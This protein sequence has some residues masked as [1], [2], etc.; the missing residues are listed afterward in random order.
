MLKAIKTCR[1][2]PG[3]RSNR[4]RA[5]ANRL[6]PKRSARL[7]PT[8]RAGHSLRRLLLLSLSGVRIVDPKLRELGVTLPGFVERGKTIASLPSLSMLILAAHTPKNWHV[9]YRDLDVIPSDLV[10]TIVSENYEV[11]A[12]T[13]LTARIVEAYALA[14]Q[15]RSENVFVV[16]GGLHV[17]ALPEEA[18]QH[19]DAIVV[20]EGEP[21][22][23]AL[24]DDATNG[25]NK[26]VYRALPHRFTNADPVPRYDLIAGNQYNRITIQTCRGCPLD[27]SFCG[28]SRLISRF[29]CKPVDLLRREIET[30]LDQWSDPF[31]E[32]ADDNTFVHKRHGRAVARLLGEYQMAWFTETDI[33][34]ADDDE[35]LALLAES[36]CRQV[37]IG[38]ESAV[39]DSLGGIDGRQWKHQQWRAYREK[40]RRIQSAGISVNGCFVLGFDQDT[41]QTF[42]R[43]REFVEELEL[44]DVQITILTPFPGT[45]L[46]GTLA[47]ELRLAD[48]PFWPQCTLFDLT[49]QPKNMTASELHSGFSWLMQTLYNADAQRKRRRVFAQMRARAKASAATT[50]RDRITHS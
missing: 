21:V 14:D 15:L 41:P 2:S 42:E 5:S 3:N 9:D 23:R 37:L 4:V 50:A 35:L 47:R 19:A 16:L 17:S 32:L 33:S 31:I 49:F 24:L 26:T 48:Q 39:H 6:L 38:L 22:W 7:A 44:A 10:Q 20:G 27:C 1:I 30:I 12:I 43:T 34:V 25:S 45:E 13:A 8:M 36:N 28:A 18:I 11:V 40:V 29:K 46:Y